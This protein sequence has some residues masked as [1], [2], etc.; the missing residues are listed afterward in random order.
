MVE[1]RCGGG[2]AGSHCSAP[3]QYFGELCVLRRAPRTATVV[4]D[5]PTSL[6]VISRRALTSVIENAP[7]LAFKMLTTMAGRLQ[8]ADAKLL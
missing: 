6:L 8:D 4:A 3:G 2:V 1:C 7:G 5:M